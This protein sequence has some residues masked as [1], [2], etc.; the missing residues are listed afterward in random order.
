M[1]PNNS[2]KEKFKQ[3]IPSKGNIKLLHHCGESIKDK[4]L[5]HALLNLSQT[6]TK[7]S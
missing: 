4:R 5:K 7:L 6:L 2:P 1:I 3:N